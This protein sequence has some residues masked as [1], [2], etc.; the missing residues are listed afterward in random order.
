MSYYIKTLQAQDEADRNRQAA[1][2]TLK[3]S[4]DAQAARERMTPLADRLRILLGTFPADRLREGL[5]LSVLQPR[6]RGRR[7]GGCSSGDLGKALRG[8]GWQRVRCWRGGN[9]GGFSALWYPPR[10]A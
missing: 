4:A 9:D 10:S 7:G 6:L 1:E 2:T 5:S 3:A 8:L